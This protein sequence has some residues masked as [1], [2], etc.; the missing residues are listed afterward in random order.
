MY[1]TV[2]YAVKT[3]NFTKRDSQNI[4]FLQ[5]PF[6][7]F[8]KFAEFTKK[9][10]YLEPVRNKLTEPLLQSLLKKDPAQIFFKWNFLKAPVLHNPSRWLLLVCQVVTWKWHQ[11]DNNWRNN[12]DFN[13][14]IE[15][16]FVFCDNFWSRHPE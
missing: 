4:L 13:A 3:W 9:H 5:Q 16:I 1:E 10:Q 14:S 6:T 8:K 15:R 2:V 12:N 7:V 11:N